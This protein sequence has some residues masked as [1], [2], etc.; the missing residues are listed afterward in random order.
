M[1]KW[2]EE[3]RNGKRKLGEGGKVL[4]RL[5]GSRDGS[6]WG[7]ETWKGGDVLCFLPVR[8]RPSNCPTQ[9]KIGLE[10]ATRRELILRSLFATPRACL[11]LGRR[12]LCNLLAASH[13]RRVCCP[14]GR[15]PTFET[16][17]P[18]HRA[19]CS[20]LHVAS[21]CVGVGHDGRYSSTQGHAEKPA[22]PC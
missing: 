13:R 2:V 21:L 12:N 17:Q 16:L 14:P 18:H 3:F 6:I 11:E 1:E 5:R 9:A 15:H 19:M 7:S 22:A 4:D 20:C 8:R 10:W